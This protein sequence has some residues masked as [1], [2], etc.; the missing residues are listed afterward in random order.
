M[1]NY[2]E[3]EEEALIEIDYYW[4]AQNRDRILSEWQSRYGVKDE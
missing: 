1:P 2:P 3:G 4:I